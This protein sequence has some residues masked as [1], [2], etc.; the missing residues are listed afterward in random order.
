MVIQSYFRFKP[1][2]KRYRIATSVPY[3]GKLKYSL[4]LDLSNWIN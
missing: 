2:I 3:T 1:F 4:K